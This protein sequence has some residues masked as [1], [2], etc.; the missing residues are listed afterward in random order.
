[1]GQPYGVAFTAAFRVWDADGETG[2]TGLDPETELSIYLLRDGAATAVTHTDITEIARGWYAVDV[3]AA[4]AECMD[5]I[6]EGTCTIADCHVE[7]RDIE[8][9][10]GRALLEAV[11][12][13]YDGD[14]DSVAWLLGT[15]LKKT[16]GPTRVTE[17]AQTIYEDAIDGTE[18]AASTISSS[19]GVTEITED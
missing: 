3:S 15:L 13:D 10:N 11:W 8:M 14:E 6:I 5:L 2:K 19:G 18:R 17:T 12:G 1:M 16:L 4:Q 9:D 7:P